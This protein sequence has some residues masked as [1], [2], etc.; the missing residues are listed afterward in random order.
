MHLISLPLLL[1]RPAMTKPSYADMLKKPSNGIEFAPR[2][3]R[4]NNFPHN[5]R[6]YNNSPFNYSRHVNYERTDNTPIQRNNYN[7]SYYTE[8]NRNQSQQ[9]NR[10]D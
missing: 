10:N 1:K 5:R 4:H 9:H 3:N 8:N 7:R 2:M 6:H